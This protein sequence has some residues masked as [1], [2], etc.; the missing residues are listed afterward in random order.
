M[1]CISESNP[2]RKIILCENKSDIQLKHSIPSKNKIE[3]SF[4]AIPYI[5]LSCKKNTGF[6]D[7]FFITNKILEKYA[8]E[9]FAYKRI[10][11]II[12]GRRGIVHD[13]RYRLG[14]R[15]IYKEFEYL[16]YSVNN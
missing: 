7:L 10:T 11:R 15:R 4:V 14:R 3:N 9:Y 5:E 12:F 13:I 16:E 6:D 1:K 2:K 8:R